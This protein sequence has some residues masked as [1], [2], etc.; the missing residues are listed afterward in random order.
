MSCPRRKVKKKDAELIGCELI[1][2]PAL[3]YSNPGNYIRQ[4][5]TIAKR[6]IKTSK[7]GVLWANQ[8]DNLANQKGHFETT[9][10]EIWNQMNYNIDAFTCAVGTGGTLSGVGKFLK[11]QNNDI[12]IVL[13]LWISFI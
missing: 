11:K 1:L 5:E 2:V 12:Q 9:G 6:L 3:P 13:S 8:F 10:K 7:K 4:S